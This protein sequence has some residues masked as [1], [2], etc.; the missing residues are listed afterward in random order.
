[1]LRG[2]G[3]GEGKSGEVWKSVLG[4]GKEKKVWGCGKVLA[5]GKVWE[6]VLGCG[7]GMGRCGKVLGEV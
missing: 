4:C 2:V 1:M 5:V 3:K 6:S 7:E